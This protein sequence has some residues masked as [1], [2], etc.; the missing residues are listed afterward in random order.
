[1]APPPLHTD[2]PAAHAIP[3]VPAGS[4]SWFRVSHSSE[5]FQP[6]THADQLQ[7]KLQ[8]PTLPGF[9]ILGESV[10]GAGSVIFK[11][12]QVAP[13]RTVALK[14]VGDSRP[15]GPDG[16]SR[17]WA[18]LGSLTQLQHPNIVQIYDVGQLD[19]RPFLVLEYV[20]GDP[21]HRWLA[22]TPPSP[23]QA[24]ALVEPVARAIQYAHVRG[25][26]HRDLNPSNILLAH[27]SGRNATAD[28]VD[29]AAASR[30]LV[31][32]V[33][34]KISGFCVASSAPDAEAP[35]YYGKRVGTPQYTSPEQS[36]LPSDRVGPATDIYA[37]GA[38][39]YE[40]L[41]GRPPFVGAST[42]ETALLS[43]TLDPVPPRRLRPRT[44]KDLETICLKCLEKD[45][46]RRYATAADL[47]DDL[48]RFLNDEPVRARPVGPLRQLW[49]WR[50]RR[51]RL[52]AAASL[53]LLPAAL[54]GIGGPIAAV[55]YAAAARRAEDDR[56]RALA[57]LAA[58]RA[59]QSDALVA[60]VRPSL[61]RELKLLQGQWAAVKV[62]EKLPGGF[63]LAIHNSTLTISYFVGGGGGMFN[64]ENV[65]APFEL[66][67]VGSQTR[68]VPTKKGTGVSEITYRV[69][70]GR[71]IIDAGSCGKIS[72]KGEWKRS[73]GQVP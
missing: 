28:E 54:L 41:T 45:P 35:H 57:D 49:R 10:G 71:L 20:E 59:A 68:I 16:T 13:E 33:V 24:A 23:H 8:W 25:V 36:Q 1:M 44:P 69:N 39:L 21:L 65:E 51:P 38:I 19:G 56:N 73:E 31:A 3:E 46:L 37:L 47:A 62:D 70:G 40:M 55:R 26:V 53:A 60:D 52:A 58:L 15:F 50:G 7:E 72:L 11:A 61:D 18:K 14:W 27:G 2:T 12:R 6:R 42:A 29:H 5:K 32:A 22:R 17:L 48:R 30:P 63:V 67:V 4:E 34:P 43:Q 64:V 66:K 9:E